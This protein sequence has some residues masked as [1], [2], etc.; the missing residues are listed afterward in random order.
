[1]P[2]VVI[3]RNKPKRKVVLFTFIALRLIIFLSFYSI[4][5]VKR[6]INVFV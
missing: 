3:E 2:I 5:K 1:M 6:I 4:M